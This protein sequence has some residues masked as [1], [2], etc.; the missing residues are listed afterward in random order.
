MGPVEASGACRPAS[1]LPET[2]L[3]AFDDPEPLRMRHRQPRWRRALGQKP[4]SE[5]ARAESAQNRADFRSR[6]Y[7][8]AT[9]P[10]SGAASLKYTA[11]GGEQQIC[12]AWRSW[13]L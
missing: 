9:S 2:G 1:R 7:I 13:F 4:P 12:F 3:H 5:Q 6:Q 10:L 11:N 8:S